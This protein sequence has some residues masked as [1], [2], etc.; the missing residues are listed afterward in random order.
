[1]LLNEM[2]SEI[3]IF[4]ETSWDTTMRTTDGC[5]MNWRIC[6]SFGRFFL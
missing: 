5:R 3:L 4:D 1:M 6:L 2:I